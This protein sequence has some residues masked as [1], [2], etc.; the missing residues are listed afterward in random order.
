MDAISSFKGLQHLLIGFFALVAKLE[1][2]EIV[3]HVVRISA[4]RHI[5]VIDEFLAHSMPFRG[6]DREV[7]RVFLPWALR[8]AAID[9]P[10]DC[11]SMSTE[12][13]RMISRGLLFFMDWFSASAHE[14]FSAI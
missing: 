2:C 8:I 12:P 13:P 11:A 5:H 4:E 6:I 7:V 1:R 3:R 10:R 9:R 14:N